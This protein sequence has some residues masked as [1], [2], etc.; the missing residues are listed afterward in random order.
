MNSLAMYVSDLKH[1]WVKF[2][3]LFFT[4]GTS[5]TESKSLF[6]EKC[7]RLN[8]AVFDIGT[9]IDWILLK[10]EIPWLLDSCL[11]FFPRVVRQ[12]CGM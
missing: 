5:P 12:C 9:R 6:Q 1:P 4:V 7:M 8:E 10:G 11:G 3:S 2:T